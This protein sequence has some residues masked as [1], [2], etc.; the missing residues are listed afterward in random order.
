MSARSA[1]QVTWIPFLLLFLIITVSGVFLANELLGIKGTFVHSDTIPVGD[2]LDMAICGPAYLIVMLA[3]HHIAHG[4][5]YD[6]RGPY[7]LLSI[8]SLVV[9][10]Y[11][12]SMHAVGNAIHTTVTELRP[13]ESQI[14]KTALL[15]MYFWDETLG[16]LLY[17]IGWYLF[18]LFSMLSQSSRHSLC[19]SGGGD[20]ANTS[21]SHQFTS[22]RWSRVW[23]T[24][25]AL[26]MGVAHTIAF[27]EGDCPWLGLALAPA[28]I[29]LSV[30]HVHTQQ[31]HFQRWSRWY[32]KQERD[33][34]TKQG[35]AGHPSMEAVDEAE[36]TQCHT[37][38]WSTLHSFPLTMHCF[39]L[40][41]LLL[42]LMTRYVV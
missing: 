20:I 22:S 31:Q 40:G 14:S 12:H 11:G 38:F 34:K 23:S 32:K 4:G 7:A 36:A 28:M 25:S 17:F 15:Q 21:Y 37:S 19:I 13:N 30:S 16:H 39:Y 1:S 29:A 27:I 8:V 2:F 35:N 3:I 10:L 33:S 24:L 41:I 5:R 9:M 26:T 42:T 18:M 6:G